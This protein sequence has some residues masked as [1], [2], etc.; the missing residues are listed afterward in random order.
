M[1]EKIVKLVG[2]KFNVNVGT[3]YGISGRQRINTQF[4]VDKN[5]NIT[6]IKISGPHHV[7]ETEAKRV[8]NKIP[9]MEPGLQGNVPVGVIYTLPIVY[10]ARN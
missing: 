4:T 6:D 5:G 7:L 1:S 9:K 10:D 2:K 3:D 8:I